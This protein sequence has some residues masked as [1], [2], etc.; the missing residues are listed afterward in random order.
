MLNAEA[1]LRSA[2]AHRGVACRLDL[3]VSLSRKASKTPAVAERVQHDPAHDSVAAEVINL[4]LAREGQVD[5]V[6]GN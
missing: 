1:F 5:D 6:A 4:S 3:S 2:C